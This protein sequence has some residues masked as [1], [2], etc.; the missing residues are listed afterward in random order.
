M[1]TDRT[2]GILDTDA[3]KRLGDDNP[4]ATPNTGSIKCGAMVN[5][6][7]RRP[8]TKRSIKVLRL[9]GGARSSESELESDAA[10]NPTTKRRVQDSPSTDESRKAKKGKHE[11][12][13]DH[14]EIMKAFSQHVGWIEQT[15][16]VERSKKL[17][18]AS[19]EAMIDK[20]ACIRDLFVAVCL[21]NSRLNGANNTHKQNLA[22]VLVECTAKIVEKKNE[23]IALKDRVLEL[24]REIASLQASNPQGTNEPQKS[25][26][27]MAA[28]TRPSRQSNVKVDDKIRTRS[29]SEGRKGTKTAKQKKKEAITKNRKA[30][31]GP[32]F[33]LICED[34]SN[35]DEVKKDV[36][37][38][39]LSKTKVPR[40]N[41]L[42]GKRNLIIIP[43]DGP[44]LEVL[45]ST[46]KI[47]EL[48]PRQ[49][50]LIIYNV[51]KDLTE[52]DVA[53]GLQ[54]QNPELGLTDDD[55]GHTRVLF[56]TGPK[57][58]S[59]VHWVLET[60]PDV[61]CK[62]ENKKVFIGMSRCSVKLHT[63]Q[64][65]CYNCQRFGHTAAKC[66]DK[67]KCKNCAGE[68]GSRTCKADFQKCA[69][70]KGAHKA[71]SRACKTKDR[72]VMNSLR[73]TDFGNQ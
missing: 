73:R 43:D 42:R 56:K 55:I 39:V 10:S 12:E 27:S 13:V 59:F 23:N 22:D 36:W 45:R 54:E 71:T 20:V 6:A 7:R 3:L 24:E 61:F 26:A 21:E 32:R 38:E 70:C 34:P 35:I 64:T 50:R 28:I 53:N 58:K 69:N 51:E 44:T 8:R 46:N 52:A 41:V 11:N 29:K 49:P 66:N 57:D 33:E 68:H 47:R 40:V 1:E 5:G 65:Q 63:A 16:T 72:V 30:P 4:V 14:R 31:T 62:L 19:A 18:V 37:K 17:T 25:Y 48:G 67:P 15:I 60:P 2:I 9:R